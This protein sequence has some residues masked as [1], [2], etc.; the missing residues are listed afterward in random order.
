MIVKGLIKTIDFNDNSCMVRIPLFETAASRGEVVLKAIMLVQPGMYN[1]FVEG[2]VVFVDF[3]N[4]DLGQPIV[5]G[6]LYL[7][8]AKEASATAH[9][10]LSVSNLEVTSKATLP[11]DTRIVVEDIGSTVPV[12]NGITSYKTISDIIKAL[13]RTE[14]ATDQ[15]YKDQSEMITTI[16]VEYLSQPAD[17]EAPIAENPNWSTSTPGHTDGYFIWQK[18]TCYNNR[19]QVLSIE[20]ICL[21]EVSAFAY[22]RLR[23]SSK[24]HAAKNQTEP[25]TITAMVKLGSN[26]EVKDEAA[27][28]A[29]KWSGED[30][31]TIAGPEVIFS[32]SDLKESN[33]IITMLREG[34]V[35]DTETIQYA[36]LNTPALIL[37]N[38]TDS[39]TY[40]ANGST[41]LSDPVSST[42]KLYLN[43]EVFSDTEVRYDWELINCA[44]IELYDPYF[45]GSRFIEDTDSVTVKSISSRSKSGQ[46]ICRATV[47]RS[48]A[49]N[50]N[51]YEKTFTVAQTRVGEN[52]TSYWLASSCTVHT[53]KK[54]DKP[55]VITAMKQYGTEKE[56][57]DT[58]S[59]IWW[60]YA[61]DT[62]W[63]QAV[64]I[65]TDMSGDE[66]VTSKIH[67]RLPFYSVTDEDIIVLATHEN[68]FNPNDLDEASLIL[69]PAIYER[70]EIPF[71]PLNTP[72]IN[73]TN[74]MGAFVCKSDGTKLNKEDVTKTTAELWLN[75][76]KLTA[77]VGYKW[78]LVDCKTDTGLTSIAS[79]DLT[80]KDISADVATATCTAT[81][82]GESYTKVF[83]VVKQYQGRSPYIIDVYNDFVSLPTNEEGKIPEAFL[84]D[85][86]VALTTHT[87]SCYYGDEPLVI[88]SYSAETPTTTDDLYRIRYL[89]DNG[90]TL[91]SDF[92]GPS[93]AVTA[94]ADT[95]SVGSIK[96]ELYKGTTKLATA[97]FELTKQRQGVS[98]TSFW[99]D[100]TARVHRGTNQQDNITATAW[101]KFG[102]NAAVE[103]TDLYLRY[104]WRNT[105]GTFDYC[106][107]TEITCGKLTVLA[108]VP[109]ADDE[110]IKVSNFKN[111]DLVF[112]LGTWD[113]DTK[114]FTTTDSELIT[115]SPSNTPVLDL[116]NDSATL[117][118]RASGKKFGEGVVV[119]TATLYL[120]G[121]A[122]TEGVTYTWTPLS[123]K[124]TATNVT[125]GGN[126]V[127]SRLSVSELT[128]DTMEFTCTAVLDNKKLFKDKV[129][130]SK[131]F[132]VSKQIQGENSISY[133]LKLSSGVHLG[134]NQKN[135]LTVTAMRKIG[136][137]LLEDVDES[138]KLFYQFKGDSFWFPVEVLVEGKTDA[139][140]THC[141]ILNPEDL[142]EDFEFKDR[143]LL[144][145]AI[146][147]I[148]EEVDGEVQIKDVE[149]ETESITYSPLNTPVLDL[150][151]DTDTLLYPAKPE[152][153][154]VDAIEF[155]DA[156]GTTKYIGIP[157][158]SPVHSKATLYLNGDAF[159]A[160]D[161]EYTWS[162]SNCI[163]DI[164]LE[165]AATTVEG[166]EVT[167][168]A[169]TTEENGKV[170]AI[171]RATC[172]AKIVAEGPFQNKRYTKVFTVSKTRKGDNAIVYSLVMD[173]ADIILDPN[174][175]TLDP[176][177]LTGTCQ[178]HD[179]NTVQPY[180]L[181]TYKYKF[182]NSTSYVTGKASEDGTFNI[183]L[184]KI[185]GEGEEAVETNLL[186]SKVEICLIN[187]AGTIVDKE[188]VK[189]V[190]DGLNGTD[191]APGAPGVSIIS[192]TTY[193]ALIHNKYTSDS[194][195]APESDAATDL[196]VKAKAGNTLNTTGANKETL[197][198]W[199]T[200]P[201]AQNNETNGWK[202]WTTVR[203]E[204]SNET[205]TFSNPI[206]NED[207]SG[208][209]ALAQGKT[210]NY[211][212]NIDPIKAGYDVKEGD[213][214]FYTPEGGG[215]YIYEEV[216]PQPSIGQEHLY[217]GYYITTDELNPAAYIEVTADN[218]DELLSGEGPITLEAGKTK[219]Y[220]RK[221]DP[222][223]TNT[224][225]QWNGSDWEDIGSEIVA[226]KVT[227]QFI[228]A[229]DVTAKKIKIL[230]TD[231]ST[232]F[233]ADGLDGNHIVTIGGFEV[234]KNVLTTGDTATGNLIK[235]S[236]NND[237]VYTIGNFTSA[238]KNSISQS[239]WGNSGWAKKT[240][241]FQRKTE[242]STV[243]CD[244]VSHS[245]MIEYF[246][247]NNMG[248]DSAEGPHYYAITKVT[249]KVATEEFKIYLTHNS[250]TEGD[251]LL[252][253]VINPSGGIPNS[254][255]SPML[256]GSTYGISNTVVEVTYSNIKPNDYF[257][258]VYV[259]GSGPDTWDGDQN[260]QHN[261]SYK[262]TVYLPTNI[263][264]TI[265]DNF[266]V[267][268]DGTVYAKN[269][270]LG[271]SASSLEN[272]ETSTAGTLAAVKI[273]SGGED[274]KRSLDDDDLPGVYLGPDGISIGTGFKV[275]AGGQ[276]I[277]TNVQ[278]TPEQMESFTA[279]SYWL[280]SSCTVHA[281]LK[282]EEAITVT[283]MKKAGNDSE[284]ADTDAYIWWKYAFEEDWQLATPAH[285][286]LE[287]PTIQLK[288]ADIYIVATHKEAPNGATP[289]YDPNDSASL[290]LD[291][292]IYEREEIPFSPLNTPIINL[293][294]D[295]AAIAYKNNIKIKS[296]DSVTTTAELWLNGTKITD[297]SKVSFEWTFDNCNGTKSKKYVTSDTVTIS[298]LSANTT[299]ATCVA[300]YNGEEYSKDFTIVKQLQG[301]DSTSYWINCSTPVHTG[302]NQTEPL[303]ITAMMKKGGDG[304]GI[305]PDATIYY[306]YVGA[307]WTA[308]TK[309]TTV[310]IDAVEDAD[311]IISARHGSD[312]A[313]EYDRETITYSPLNTPVLDL[314]NDNASIAY[315]GT[316]K[317][318]SS[319]SSTAGVYLNGGLIN[320]QM[321][322]LWLTF[323]CTATLGT[324]QTNLKATS[325]LAWHENG[326]TV[327]AQ[328]IRATQNPTIT[329]SAL[330]TNNATAS[331][332]AF[333]NL[334]TPE[335]FVYR[336]S[337]TEANWAAYGAID[338]EESWTNAPTVGL[339]K[340]FVV[341]GKS[342]DT[343]QTHVLWYR[344]TAA[345]TTAFGKC[346]AHKVFYEKDFTLTKQLKGADG[347]SGAS[348]IS[349]EIENDFDSIPCNYEGVVSYTPS[350]YSSQ[351]AHTLRLFEGT[352]P[353]DFKVITP[354]P[355]GDRPDDTS[356]FIT[357]TTENVSATL[358]TTTEAVSEYTASITSLNADKGKIKYTVYKGND[359]TVLATGCFTAEKRYSAAPVVKIDIINDFVS[360]PCNS[361]NTVSWNSTKLQTESEHTISV[362]EGL[363]PKTF[364]VVSSVPTTAD[365]SYRVHQYST[366]VTVV[367]NTMSTAASS[368]TNKISAL[369]ADVG[370]ITYD[371]YKGTAKISS[372]KFE[373]VKVPAGAK[374]TSGE[375]YKLLSSTS[376]IKK[377]K[378]GN[379]TPTSIT[380]NATKQVGTSAATAFTGA[381]FKVYVDGSLTFSGQG[382]VKTDGTTSTAS[383]GNYVFDAITSV[384]KELKVELYSSSSYTVLLDRETIPV[385]IDGED[386]VDYYF[387]A[388][389]YQVAKD[390]NTDTY[391]TDLVTFTVYKQ[392]G[393]DIPILMDTA[394]SEASGV[395]FSYEIDDEGKEDVE[396]GTFEVV[397]GPHDHQATV[398]VAL[399][400]KSGEGD[401]AT[402]TLLDTE[403][404]SV[405]S[406]GLNSTT[407]GPA[408]RSVLSTIKYYK[409]CN[410]TLADGNQPE[411]S[412]ANPTEPTNK[413]KAD[414]NKG[415]QVSPPT[416]VEGY[417][418]YETVRTQYNTADN[419]GHYYSWSVPVKNAMLTV[420]F[421]N[422]LGITAKRLEVKSSDDKHTIFLAD[423]YKRD[424]A[425]NLDPTVEIGGFKVTETSIYSENENIKLVSDGGLFAKDA[426]LSGAV[427]A[428]SL[429]IGNQTLAV[430]KTH[431]DGLALGALGPTQ[432]IATTQVS[433]I[434]SITF[435]E[436]GAYGATKGLVVNVQLDKPLLTPM[437]LSLRIQASYTSPD[438]E[439]NYENA[440]TTVPLL[441]HRTL[442][443]GETSIIVPLCWGGAGQEGAYFNTGSCIL[444]DYFP[445]E[446]STYS[447]LG[448][449]ERDEAVTFDCNILPAEDK[450]FSLGSLSKGK[451]W[452]SI[453][454]EYIQAEAFRVPY[455]STKTSEFIGNTK[456]GYSS[457]AEGSTPTDTRIVG[458]LQI[459]DQYYTY[460]ND[461]RTSHPYPGEVKFYSIPTFVNGF[462][463]TGDL[464]IPNN[465]NFTGQKT[466]MDTQVI[467]KKYLNFED[468]STLM[469]TARLSSAF[470]LNSKNTFAKALTNSSQPYGEKEFS[471]INITFAKGYS[472]TS[473]SNKGT[474]CITLNSYGTVTSAAA[475]ELATFD[476]IAGTIKFANGTF[477]NSDSK[478][479][480]TIQPLSTNQKYEKLFDSLQPVSY[481]L[482]DG[483]SGRT[484][485]GLIA[486]D[487]KQA[488]LDSGLTTTDV[489]AYGEWELDDS[490]DQA[491]KATCGIRY[492]ELIALNIQEI[493]KL[494]N[495]VVQQDQLITDLTQRLEKL[496]SKN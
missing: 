282:H 232:L 210:T 62:E 241:G 397:F 197:G 135:T 390:P 112:E 410:Q 3:E 72:I 123:D 233:E 263:R 2:D 347:L 138:A 63:T 152:D 70:E 261:H 10:A 454:S 302:S 345:G 146:H 195:A 495:R 257:Y 332:W 420:D 416:F 80:V 240:D 458:N 88:D 438:P 207:L 483:T 364:T 95:L 372:T 6:K 180:G 348:P 110:S 367:N 44:E 98:A 276:P 296:T 154:L 117:S 84:D 200:T 294:N 280:S 121:Q 433:K 177:V 395:A 437:T 193:Y 352:T 191:G 444:E 253:S 238:E 305:D 106:A 141:L 319:V 445:K 7:G 107:D 476:M 430:D 17:A 26:L 218:L 463:V 22:Y 165:D 269:L 171:G 182:D 450:K 227:A 74:D 31:E 405:V 67:Y 435:A 15:V 244:G 481:K 175:D 155:T 97:K 275:E 316:T 209:Y 281:G 474:A 447:D 194:I 169:F 439:S 81:Y 392:V 220:E 156:D 172:T 491:G 324:G 341:L 414:R 489:A 226:N 132:T 35:C 289:G 229:L 366:S 216:S 99:V 449:I 264:L 217:V 162:L 456:L 213:C 114:V 301:S 401:T 380:F 334:Y 462:A 434:T 55:V 419:N 284:C 78:D 158:G 479:K 460:E 235:L 442:P 255:Q 381:Y 137:E 34:A 142:P 431:P 228:N 5:I 166:Q 168:A 242:L 20:I 494:K 247:T 427:S 56:I 126:L 453:E 267:L 256:Q 101:S 174:T 24:L 386:A 426:T 1:G 214:W 225:Y 113:E 382:K 45:I 440:T 201:P 77:G 130:I 33:L 318:G 321:E 317:L 249:F 279:T 292:N 333:E 40:A 118:Y 399:Y 385:V 28:I 173:H 103:N 408:G 116:S 260:D 100:Y 199:N 356:Y 128:A 422:A 459:G 378:Q 277:I 96:Y 291:T 119:S 246:A 312:E 143:D 272:S 68:S 133:W 283:A 464:N 330:S 186:S 288:D 344:S 377:D 115:Y 150:D 90:I 472:G 73:L 409:L 203:T 183:P 266:Q 54:H 43:G 480:N 46:A 346:V 369:S 192:Q 470:S 320:G 82:Q 311:L 465:V 59:I 129:E 204:F 308:G 39:I 13:Y 496:E 368:Y 127:G 387:L 310:T 51:V 262:G 350:Q 29:Y 486:Q 32:A 285:N 254:F 400:L 351:T 286:Y 274:Q 304:E 252:T 12:E 455:G 363:T 140:E 76:S 490:E 421:L 314:S 25:I 145:K 278:L 212:S 389:C 309:G 144:V 161:V 188:T 41:I 208:V 239:T 164:D 202:Y 4:E 93:F 471:P 104:G 487:L 443:A 466:S 37:S 111:A 398:N 365:S 185:T 102:N 265:G 424:A 50:S 66:P 42:A 124:N 92:M 340:Y 452:E 157:L 493:Q 335:L 297:E 205:V 139:Y 151:N 295:S 38:D 383:T 9:S 224:L 362:Y 248:G 250:N 467:I 299:T 329:I 178:T 370:T 411:N 326:G 148:T 371:L 393:N 432:I 391:D 245:G 357:Y 64:E 30:T 488:I 403:T 396:D 69:H 181:A 125:E 14:A 428:R 206:I 485:F 215:G 412:I 221:I 406:E 89:V 153:D 160:K 429:K 58:A 441:L 147:T 170:A 91:S 236:S 23:C 404:I 394:A 163:T 109:S 222:R 211:Y 87:L 27:T 237:N 484:H 328:V 418:Y 448:T 57:I 342:T 184:T 349:L 159:A 375:S 131:V 402:Y 86:L 315:E 268:A 198:A 359:D 85:D 358:T 219:C 120:D 417:D 251:Y 461:I 243:V 355:A 413:T 65:V 353:K 468:T 8:A 189:I 475:P 322:M 190:K 273:I 293:T 258:M 374:G 271:A 11:I 79:A 75:G 478:I 473:S 223:D 354:L 376:Q 379:T 290:S 298:T 300:T 457:T 436:R 83:K 259:H 336:S 19:G 49:F 61:S 21:S 60:K 287:I 482:N 384:T 167:V 53:G 338:H 446:F 423:G 343:A 306:K 94:V 52:S 187:A 469:G 492:E 108:E 451:A 47:L 337:F 325:T 270:F 360:V 18:T 303:T 361:S 323:G 327:P 388:D 48:G 339:G 136:T 71:S 176:K 477:T 234:E 407:P 415:W 313:S 16:K 307:N 230:D 231:N 331:C 122:V 425:D 149:Y 105:N 196:I 373:A 179:G 36:P 134:V